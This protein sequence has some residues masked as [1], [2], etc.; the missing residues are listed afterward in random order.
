[1]ISFICDT[2]YRALDTTPNCKVHGASMGSP[3]ELSAPGGPHV[4]PMNLAIWDLSRESANEAF[5]VW[6]QA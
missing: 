6:L 3:R 2:D 1:M 4:G 5:V